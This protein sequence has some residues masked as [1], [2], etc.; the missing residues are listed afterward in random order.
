MSRLFITRREIDF[1]SDLTKEVVKD[2]IGQKIFYY[3][4]SATKTRIHEVY[5]EAPEKV[6]E[7]PLEVDALVTWEPEEVRTNKFGSE[8]FYGIEVFLH[9]RDLLD[10]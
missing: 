9:Q 1:I 7:N 3:S 5:E 4:I 2:V 8:E 10:K 6:F